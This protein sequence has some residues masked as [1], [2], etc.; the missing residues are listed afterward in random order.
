MSEESAPLPQPVLDIQ[1]TQWI[2]LTGADDNRPLRLSSNSIVRSI[3]NVCVSDS[4]SRSRIE[5][6]WPISMGLLDGLGGKAPSV[7]IS[8]YEVKET[9]DE[10]IAAIEGVGKRVRKARRDLAWNQHIAQLRADLAGYGDD[11]E[12]IM[13]DIPM[14]SGFSHQGRARIRKMHHRH[15]KGSL[16]GMMPMGLEPSFTFGPDNDDLDLDPGDCG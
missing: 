5:V 12:E 7:G 13:P 10:V 2:E 15:M 16:S 3:Q 4:D 6:A 1:R 8:T 9:V 11:E 14:P